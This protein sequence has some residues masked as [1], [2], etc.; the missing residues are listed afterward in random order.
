MDRIEGRA[1]DPD[2]YMILD[3]RPAGA[4]NLQIAVD[5]AELDP[6]P[7]RA[8]LLSIHS[9]ICDPVTRKRQAAGIDSSNTD[10]TETDRKAACTEL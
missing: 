2:H 4:A 7:R 5:A 9:Q 6:D 8:E 10:F 3:T 1:Q